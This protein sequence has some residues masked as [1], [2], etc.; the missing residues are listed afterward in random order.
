MQGSKPVECE[1]LNVIQAAGIW[2]DCDDKTQLLQ[3]INTLVSG[4]GNGG[5]VGS[6]P[7]GTVLTYAGAT[8]PEGFMLCDGTEL[9]AS[10]HVDLFTLIGTVYGEGAATGSFKLPDLRGRT[11]IGVGQGVNLTDRVLGATDGAETHQ[12]TIDEMP[13]H[14]HG[15]TFNTTGPHNV[16]SNGNGQFGSTGLTGG[17]QPHN[18]MQP[19]V[20][21]NYI[22]K[23]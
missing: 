23:V 9:L 4:G 7:I 18:N 19:F 2:P 6:A 11:A 13:S 21:L 16:G 15:D 1:V 12:L 5:N 20:V 14:S 10:E 17:N 3:A 22:I 8:A